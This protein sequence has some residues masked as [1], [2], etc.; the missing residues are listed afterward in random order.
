M[1][2]KKQLFTVVVSL[3]ATAGLLGF[4]SLS[5]SQE[6]N[7]IHPKLEGDIK[8]LSKDLTAL[9]SAI[10]QQLQQVQAKQKL[11][12]T[13]LEKQCRISGDLESNSLCSKEI[14]KYKQDVDSMMKKYQAEIN[15]LKIQIKNEQ[16]SVSGSDGSESTADDTRIPLPPPPLEA[17]KESVQADVDSSINGQIKG[18][19]LGYTGKP[20]PFTREN[21]ISTAKRII[22]RFQERMSK[23]KW[24]NKGIWFSE[25]LALVAAAVLGEVD[26]IFESGTAGGQSAE[27]MGRFIEGSHV[28]LYT[29]DNGSN[30]AASAFLG[31]AA[32][33]LKPIK[34][35]E[36]LTAD[37]FKMI[38]ELITGKHKG[39]RVGAFVDGPKGKGGMKLCMIALA[40]S[41]NVKWCGLHDISIGHTTG[42]AVAQWE[43]VVGL[44]YK[45]DW[46]NMF[47]F[48]DAQVTQ[49]EKQKTYAF[50][51]SYGNGVAIVAGFEA[52]PYGKAAGDEKHMKG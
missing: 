31:E 7:C 37:S 38:P 12:E 26:V 27:V 25:G 36:M 50:D 30:Q 6:C 33:R 3:G 39:Q 17:A 48:L 9:A 45:D 23:I 8:S 18:A 20:L 24:V 51:K 41:N 11:T 15:T 44:T 40:A 10:Q 21:L 42:K 19:D 28:K 46:K 52:V 47:G 5:L 14:S 49:E 32:K 2:V 22:P 34:N 29:I 35:V 16:C 4:A 43:R 1:S 13:Q